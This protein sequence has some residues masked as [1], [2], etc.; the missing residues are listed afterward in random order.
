MEFD[1]IVREII[2]QYGVN[3]YL[4][5][6][7][8]LVTGIL[9]IWV[10][11]LIVNLVNYFATRMSDLGYG[12]MILWEGKLKRVV[13]IKFKFI[14]VVDDEEIKFI[15]IETWLKSIQTFPQPRVDQFDE[16]KWK[17]RAWDGRTE[18]RKPNK[19]VNDE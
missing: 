17:E 8:L 16:N 12:T 10:K 19:Q 13:E 5:F 15:P 6:V 18:R 14:K 11:N 2:Q 9:T 3:L 1:A 4:G 7:T